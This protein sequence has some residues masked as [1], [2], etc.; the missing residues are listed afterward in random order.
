M[1]AA[2]WI[3]QEELDD[4]QSEVIDLPIGKSY[5]VWG[6][7]GSGKTNLLLL[8]ANYLYLAHHP[9]L[10]IIVFTRALQEFISSGGAQY[11]FPSDK[12]KTSTRFWMDLLFQYGLTPTLPSDFEECRKFLIDQIEALIDTKKLKD[13][14]DTILLDESQ[15]YL[16][17]EIVLFRRLSKHLF[18]TADSRQKIYNGA[19]PVDELRAAVAKEITLPYHYRIGR[20][21]CKV[22]DILMKDSSS[23]TLL[24]PG[25]QYDEQALPS[26]VEVVPCISVADQAN[27]IIAALRVQLKAYPGELLGVICPTREVLDGVRTEIA[28]SDFADVCTMQGA[29]DTLSFSKKTCVCVCTLHAAKGLEFRTVHLAGAEFLKK[30]RN[31]RKMAFTAVTRAKTTLSVY[32]CATLPGYLEEALDNVGP[33]KPLP[34]IK[35]VFGKKS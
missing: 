34:T 20:R 11:D 1:N 3:G 31:Q 25:S 8:R 19:D 14:Y 18:A 24:E 21:I 16:P 32:H 2:W 28:A 27:K 15:D 9:N 10:Q 17:Q 4:Q 5:L 26:N 12:L 29:S 22:A 33:S 6:P 23:Y 7:P 35:Q 13:V 30:F